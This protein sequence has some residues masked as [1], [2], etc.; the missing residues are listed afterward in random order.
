MM[1]KLIVSISVLCVVTTTQAFAAQKKD[2]SEVAKSALT[3]VTAAPGIIRKGN[4]NEQGPGNSNGNGHSGDHGHWQD[5]P[6]HC[7]K[8]VS[9]C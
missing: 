9:P 2:T 4:G 5:S 3:K 6:G 8:S 1:K 7:K